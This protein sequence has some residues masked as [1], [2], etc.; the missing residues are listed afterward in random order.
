[1]LLQ[2]GQ[3]ML[4]SPGD[5]CIICM[6]RGSPK[7]P[8][9]ELEMANRPQNFYVIC[10]T[11]VIPDLPLGSWDNKCTLFLFFRTHLH[12]RSNMYV[13]NLSVIMP[14]CA[15]G[16]VSHQETVFQIVLS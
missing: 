11:Y 2:A 8:Q 7:L 1:M 9:P 4:N 16:T 3:E 14:P 6:A 13:E 12:G 5:I 15:Q 10:M